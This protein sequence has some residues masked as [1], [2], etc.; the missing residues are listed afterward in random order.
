VR[1]F[2]TLPVLVVLL[3]LAIAAPRPALAQA[4]SGVLSPSRAI[5][6][7]SVGIPGDVPTRTTACAT[8]SPGA[9]A[10]AINSAIQAC[11]TGQVVLL[12]PGTYNLS[13]GITFGNKS[14]VTLRGGGAD[15]TRLV[16]TGSTGCHYYGNAFV[17][18]DSSDTNWNGGPSNSA[19]WTGGYSKGT[20]V[21]TLSNTSN[22]A[23]GKMIILDQLNDSVDS[24]DI[25]VCEG[26][27]CA[28]KGGSGAAR[29]NR[30]QMALHKVVSVT[31]N[32]VTITP[33]IGM[34][35]WRGSQS[36]QAWWPSRPI[37]NSGIEDLTIDYSSDSSA[38]QGATAG[39]MFF[40]SVN[41]WM[42]GVRSLN[43]MRNHVYLY[44]SYGTVLQSNYFYGSKTTASTSYG[45]EW[46]PAA[47]TLVENNIF[48]HVTA[49]VVVNGPAFGDVIAYNFAVDDNY[50]AGGS[51]PGW[52]QPMMVHHSAGD[53]ML[54]WEGN[55]GLGTQADNVHG[56]HHF[57]TYFRNHF[58]GDVYNNPAKTANTTTMHFWAYSRFFNVIGNVLGRVGY[59]NT[60]ETNLSARATSVFA[61]G[62]PDSGTSQ[63]AGADPLVRTTLMRW[64]NYDT[65]T[66]NTRWD[67]SEVPTA[68]P[69]FANPVPA[70]QSLPAS[71]YLAGR[72][73]WF[74]A[75]AWPA[76]GPDVTGGNVSGYA[77]HANK[78][79]ARVCYE[80]TPSSGGILN[81][82]AAACYGGGGRST[83]PPAPATN[84]RVIR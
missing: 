52:M 69:Q 28:G 50:T 36:P 74:G 40:N 48:Q 78:I 33:A 65:V 5:D 84:V 67:S 82:N 15:T 46:F 47:M 83:T 39:V 26:S 43:A 9:T 4:W 32:S 63:T 54:L 37:S 58:Y 76:I 77:G 70:T 19:T 30:G 27:P 1:R 68:L 24:G 22:L 29:N 62:D 66:A 75:T 73:S 13:S 18:F 7:S 3:L 38:T 42:K 16:F 41:C 80:N 72:P 2:Q 25:Y 11:P 45:I 57:S 12:S 71:M 6:W 61:F 49:P 23:P 34:P 21:I 60:Y 53:G 59:Y 17:C 81:F 64:G 56:T 79:P 31:G 10:A 55:D 14:G 20:T 44:L 51:S 35:N 8:L